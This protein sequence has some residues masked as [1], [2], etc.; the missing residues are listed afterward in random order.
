MSAITVHYAN[1]SKFLICLSQGFGREWNNGG[2][3]TVLH[4]SFKLIVSNLISPVM[5]LIYGFE[6]N[7]LKRLH[8]QSIY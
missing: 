3:K 2:K 4:K 5:Q 7:Q 6:H 1:V 8:P